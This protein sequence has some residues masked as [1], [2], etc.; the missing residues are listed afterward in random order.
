VQPLLAKRA[1]ENKLMHRVQAARRWVACGAGY[2]STVKMI[3]QGE[4]ARGT[5]SSVGRTL[6][7]SLARAVHAVPGHRAGPSF[8]E[9]AELNHV[10]EE[11]M[12]PSN[13]PIATPTG[14]TSELPCVADD[15]RRRRSVGP[16]SRASPQ[17]SCD[18]AQGIQRGPGLWASTTPPGGLSSTFL[19]YRL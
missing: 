2:G 12:R 9:I 19:L 18:S 8:T 17:C 1:D 5:I 15:P 11:Q 6:I 3:Q 16:R 13:A 14:V 10:T 7:R 4:R